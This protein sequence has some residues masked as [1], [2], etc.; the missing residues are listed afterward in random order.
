MTIQWREKMTID[1]GV[2]DQDHK[3]LIDI[4]NRFEK[5]A[6]DGLTLNEGLE[7]LFAL[8]FYASTHFKR[9]EQLQR[10]IDFPFFEAH[11]RE[12]EELIEKL[13]EIIDELKTTQ[14]STYNSVARHT[15]ALLRD[16]LV[17]HVLHSDLRMKSF[18]DALREQGRDMEALASIVP[19]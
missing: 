2:I 18:I 5:T 6:Q 14:E 7:I 13:T 12:H 15:A 8:K 4:I 1:D 16:W 10:L 3:H 19:E 11:K 9:E 17:N